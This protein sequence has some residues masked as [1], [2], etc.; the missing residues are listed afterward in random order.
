MSIISTSPEHSSE[1]VNLNSSGYLARPQCCGMVAVLY[2]SSGL[3]PLTLTIRPG[4]EVLALCE[5]IL[6]LIKQKG[7]K[8]HRQYMMCRH[9]PVV[10][11][12]HYAG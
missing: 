9:Q 11:P 1:N 5:E 8:H 10:L 4:S 3:V 7:V 2:I 6:K 12:A